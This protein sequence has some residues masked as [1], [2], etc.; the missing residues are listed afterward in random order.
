MKKAW[1]YHSKRHSRFPLMRTVFTALKARYFLPMIALKL[2]VIF[3]TF[4]KPFILHELLSSSTE[5]V[6]A[7][8]Y[9]VALTVVAIL[10]AIIVH[11]YFW[12][13]EAL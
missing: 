9:S 3:L 1:E 4:V 8:S 2:V 12:Q 11:W 5:M 13:V 6:P 10:Q 7:Y